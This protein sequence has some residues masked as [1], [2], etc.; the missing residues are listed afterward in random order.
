MKIAPAK[1]VGLAIAVAKMDERNEYFQ[2][3]RLKFIRIWTDIFPFSS[4]T[5]S[6]PVE[7]I[8]GNA[9]ESR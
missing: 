6:K 8:N 2:S 1:S 9:I 5:F 4:M 3:F 7:L